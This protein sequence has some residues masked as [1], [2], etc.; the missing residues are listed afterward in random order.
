MA[1]TSPTT[2]RVQL[3]QWLLPALCV[4]SVIGVA[5]TNALFYGIG[6]PPQFGYW[7]AV[8]VPSEQPFVAQIVHTIPGGA[9][10]RAGIRDGD[11][12]SVDVR[13]L[14]VYDRVALLFQPVTSVPVGFSSCAAVRSAPS[15]SA[16]VPYM[17]GT[18]R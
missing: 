17:K 11:R 2:G 18:W 14:G 3:W 5:W 1:Q 13:D 12:Q 6:G 7:D 8:T 16:E 4:L 10:E 9:S 15:W